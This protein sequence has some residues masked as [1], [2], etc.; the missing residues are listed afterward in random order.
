[1]S[2]ADLE[3]FLETA[4]KLQREPGEILKGTIDGLELT[5]DALITAAVAKGKELG[6]QFT[7]EEVAKLIARQKEPGTGGTLSEGDLDGMADAFKERDEWWGDKS[8]KE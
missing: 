5:G 6:Y 7:N 3:K 4:I 8:S 1:M 2:Q